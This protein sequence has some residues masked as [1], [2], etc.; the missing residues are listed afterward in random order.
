VVP[1][2]GSMY[3]AV[4]HQ[5]G[6][7]LL[8]NAAGQPT[9]T[10]AIRSRVSLRSPEPGASLSACRPVPAADAWQRPVHGRFGRHRQVLPEL[11]S[12]GANRQRHCVPVVAHGLSSMGLAVTVWLLRSFSAG[13]GGR[14][15]RLEM[16]ELSH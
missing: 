6:L 1:P 9:T 7:L 16:T 12:R 5:K 8:R 13:W 14:T 10:P 15:S 2:H 11:E 4:R 3:D